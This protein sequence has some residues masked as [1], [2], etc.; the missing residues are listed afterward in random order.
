[1]TSARSKPRRTN[2]KSCNSTSTSRV[3]LYGLSVP[4]GLFAYL[5]VS[6][7]HSLS[8]GLA[9]LCTFLASLTFWAFPW[10]FEFTTQLQILSTQELPAGILSHTA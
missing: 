2:I 5:A 8:L 7:L 4:G 6:S 9:L 3:A 10:S 1:M